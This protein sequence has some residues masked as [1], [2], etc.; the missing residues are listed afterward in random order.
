MRAYTYL[1]DFHL[2]WYIENNPKKHKKEVYEY[3]KDQWLL[4]T[5]LKKQILINSI[6]GVDIDGEAVELTKLSLLLKVLENENKQN[7]EQ[8]LKL[9]QERVLP[10]LDRNIKCGNSVVDST[11]FKQSTLIS[12]SQEEAQK[13]NP[14][15][16]EDIEKGFGKILK[17]EKFDVII[18]NPP[19]VKEYTNREIFES[20]K[21]SYL[22]K[23]Y[24]GKMDFWY[25]FT[26]NA[27]D[28][29]KEGGIHSY[30]APNNWI[31]NA[32]ASILRDKILTES[33][34]IT[35]FDF[36]D[37]KVFKNASIQTMVFVIEKTKPTKT[38]S[39]NY[40]KIIDSKITKDELK[41]YLITKKDHNKIQHF[42]V[43]IN[44]TELKNKTITFTT[45]EYRDILE[46]I[47]E[48]GNYYL[49]D[50]NV[51]QGIVSPQESVIDSHFK[52]ITD[53]SIKK[54]EGI[55]VVNS[56]EINKLKLSLKEKEIIKPYF[57][58]E[59][60]YRYFGSD[61]NK[62]W[63]IYAD[64]N[65][66]KNIKEYPYIKEHLDKFKK[67]ITSDFAPYGLHRAREQRFF[68]GEKVISLRKTSK[69]FF[70]YTDFPCYVSQTY[71]VIKPSDIN[72]KYLTAL[73]NSK[74]IFFWL[75]YKGKMQGDQLQVDKAPLLEIP[76]YK[77]DNND[78]NEMKKYNEIA[79]LVDIIRDLVKR[80]LDLKIY[81]QQDL[82]QK[83]IDA[84]ESK[85]DDLIFNLYDITK[86]EQ[87]IIENSLK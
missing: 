73:L 57:T 11:Y 36:N 72:L 5:E 47:K 10:N 79:Q 49:I 38:Y 76:I 25:L 75:K 60:L 52:I 31:T 70:T 55:F 80:S 39:M 18:G 43:K 6:F 56:D 12:L 63:I 59:Q 24:Q 41:N 87:K 1:L 44:P 20:V 16:W 58:S 61:K 8:Q 74:M 40:D 67:I 71:F 3:K 62:L 85:I 28:L 78:K 66:R 83:Q 33:K 35:F 17:E 27:L 7:V 42:K 50:N 14:F 26:C 23:Y 53:N 13:I 22:S 32:G 68:E 48:R 82:I 86:E 51:A 9:F 46:K 65:V 81:L 30:I 37:Y 69:P 29:L 4:T 45:S 21:L 34:L 64:I 84:Y 77:I 54:G 19:Y 2:N 15:N